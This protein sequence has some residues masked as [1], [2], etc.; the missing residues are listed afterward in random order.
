MSHRHIINLDDD[1]EEYRIVALGKN[2]SGKSATGNS[3]LGLWTFLSIC[4]ANSV[5]EYCQYDSAIRFGKRLVYVDT[6]GFF[7]IEKPNEIIQK[8]IIKCIAL[9]SPGPHVF[10]LII[11]VDRFTPEEKA[12][13]DIYRKIFGDEFYRHL[14][15]VFTHKDMMDKSGKSLQQFISEAPFELQNVLRK[16][17]NI[18]IAIE[19]EAPPEAVKV[20]MKEMFDLIITVVERNGGRHF[21]NTTYANMEE[22]LLNEEDKE[23]KSHTEN[24]T[25]TIQDNNKSMER[26]RK[27]VGE[28]EELL[29]ALVCSLSINTEPSSMEEAQ[30]VEAKINQLDKENEMLRNE[31]RM[32]KEE[33]RRI[34]KESKERPQNPGSFR[35]KIRKMIQSEEG[36]LVLNFLKEH[37]LTILKWGII[38]LKVSMK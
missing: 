11:K 30:S 25:K 20:Q 27:D 21:T 10:L 9:S 26:K 33:I 28:E 23:R 18:C 15:V 34:E 24:L 19:N 2:G 3:F 5:T 37:G 13:I 38:A 17:K 22:R 1:V 6:P 29:Q 16:N 14:I 35:D 31:I 12:T 4:S 7:N 36:Q 8:E 32:M